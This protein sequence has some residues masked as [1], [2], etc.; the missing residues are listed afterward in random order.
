MPFTNSPY[1]RR[2][3]LLGFFYKTEQVSLEGETIRRKFIPELLVDKT[4]SADIPDP[5]SG[6]VLIKKGKR[7]TPVLI[8]KMKR[9]GVTDITGVPV[10]LVG[11]VVA[12]DILAPESGEVLAQCNEVLS[13]DKI[14]QLQE[15]GI[16]ELDLLFIDGVNYSPCLRN[17][18]AADKTNLVKEAV[19]E[20]YRRLRPSNR[21]NEEVAVSFFENLFFNPEY[22]DLSPVGR[23]KLDLKLRAVEDRL[24]LTQ[25]SR[26][27]H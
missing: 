22:Y 27:L 3:E 2:E 1:T 13:E 10:D 18:L 14:K 16:K 8:Q 6:E 19:L 11:K 21:P 7:L 24:P 9:A 12:H 15:K 4:T 5:K 17:T 20:I 23:L 25:T 26:S